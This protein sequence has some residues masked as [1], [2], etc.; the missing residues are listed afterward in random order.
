MT[1]TS[2][3]FF[4]NGSQRPLE[5]GTDLNVGNIN[6]DAFTLGGCAYGLNVTRLFVGYIAEFLLYDRDLNITEEDSLVVN[7]LSRN[8]NIDVS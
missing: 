1:E 7:Y 6:L 8:Y 3:K 2:G 4:V 5:S